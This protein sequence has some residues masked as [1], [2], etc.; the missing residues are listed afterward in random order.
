MGSFLETLYSYLHASAFGD[1]QLEGSA[2]SQGVD[3]AQ[4]APTKQHSGIVSMYSVEHKQ[5]SV[6]T[7]TSASELIEMQEG[8]L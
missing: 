2:T 3:L 6:T 8:K 7:I 1:L 5:G 4:P